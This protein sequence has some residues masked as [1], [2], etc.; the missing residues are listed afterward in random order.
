M[1][2]SSVNEIPATDIPAVCSY[3]WLNS[4]TVRH[5]SIRN[6]QSM[7]SWMKGLTRERCILQQ[8]SNRASIQTE[9]E[10]SAAS[11]VDCSW[12]NIKQ[13][14]VLVTWWPVAQSLWS[15]RVD[16]NTD[17]GCKI[18]CKHT[19]GDMWKTWGVGGLERIGNIWMS[20]AMFWW[21]T[22]HNPYCIQGIWTKDAWHK[23]HSGFLLG[24]QLWS[25]FSWISQVN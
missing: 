3:R 9:G 24:N 21:E 12:T 13:R 10:S 15:C 20:A 5:V 18:S 25:S 7:S 17:T 23:E 16:P 19:W 4:S 6:I 11:T 2:Y 8:V 1:P 14:P 22:A